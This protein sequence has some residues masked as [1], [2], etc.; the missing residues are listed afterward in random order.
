MT[1]AI[2]ARGKD[3]MVCVTDSSIAV[4]HNRI[5]SPDIKGAWRGDEFVMYAGTL[6]YAQEVLRGEGGMREAVIAAKEK[7]KDDDDD[8]SAEF[9]VVDRNG[10]SILEHTAAVVSGFDYACIGHGSTTSWPIL[11]ALYKPEMSESW[12]KKMLGTVVR[13]T[14]KYDSTVY[15]PSRF[16]VIR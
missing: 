3:C 5:T 6:Y 4:G 2:A 1:I 15:R 9:L 16:E 10:I 12:I 7:H 11:D 14:E 8:D 13:I